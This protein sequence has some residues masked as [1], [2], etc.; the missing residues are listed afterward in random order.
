MDYK[1]YNLVELEGI[2]DKE[3]NSEE[4]NKI[5]SVIID[6]QGLLSNEYEETNNAQLEEKIYQ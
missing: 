6:K 4:L 3:L 1:Q 2:F 5:M